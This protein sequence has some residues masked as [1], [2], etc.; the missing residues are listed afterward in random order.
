MAPKPRPPPPPPPQLPCATRANGS[1]IPS[2][3]LHESTVRALQGPS[4][5]AL[6]AELSDFAT[7]MAATPADVAI[8][9]AIVSHVAAATHSRWPHASVRAFGSV[10]TGLWTPDSD[11]DVLIEHGPP[12]TPLDSSLPTKKLRVRDRRRVRDSLVD[13]ANH[14]RHYST[15]SCFAIDRRS[16][17]ACPGYNAPVARMRL[18][19]Y[20]VDIAFGTSDVVIA[21]AQS[22]ISTLSILPIIR[23]VFCTLR[24]LLA[25]HGLS[26]AR[27]G[28]LASYA[29]FNMVHYVALRAAPRDASAADLLLTF[30]V[31]FDG[32]GLDLRRVGVSA[33]GLGAVYHRSDVFPRKQY[34]GISVQDPLDPSNE[35]GATCLQIRRVCTLFS[36]ARSALE[37]WIQGHQ[38]AAR[39]ASPLAEVLFVSKLP[40]GRH[41]L[42]LRKV[43][44]QDVLH[45]VD[46]SLVTSNHM[47][48]HNVQY[49]PVVPTA[50][51][52][53]ASAKL[54]WAN[55]VKPDNSA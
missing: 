39:A 40:L 31:N 50:N 49:T 55:I 21:A 36:F 29:L 2:W 15:G 24:T 53:P 19:S 41:N 16:I 54:T 10:A 3:I 26:D 1:A 44:G 38:Y 28:G 48:D 7:Y 6:N 11:V 23:P 13:F 47:Q 52:G 35:L 45:P 30:L 20:R 4:T 32:A 12:I 5:S 43:T 14:L 42:G 17:V 8:H 27:S 18:G 46:T 22:V 33:A 9:N 25:Q 37:S 34:I 51:G